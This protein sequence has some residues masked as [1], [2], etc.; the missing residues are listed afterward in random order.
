MVSTRIFQKN[1]YSAYLMI[2]I[3]K[4]NFAYFFIKTYVVCAHQKLIAK[5]F[6][7][8][9]HNIEFHEDLTQIIFKL[10]SNTVNRLIFAA[11]N[12]FAF[13]SSWA[14]CGNLFSQTAELY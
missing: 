13:L 11:I 9:T 4:D 14:F 10:S 8:S 3:L 5:A 12:F 6:L 2:I 1:R 7:M